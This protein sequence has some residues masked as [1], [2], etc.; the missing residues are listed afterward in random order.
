MGVTQLAL[1]WVWLLASP[2]SQGLTYF[3]F[4][5]IDPPPKKNIYMTPCP[6]KLTGTLW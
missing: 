1:A 3:Y 5:D 6:K 2:F 4:I